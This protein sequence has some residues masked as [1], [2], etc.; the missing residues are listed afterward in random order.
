MP[1]RAIVGHRRAVE[2]LARAVA[3][4]SVPQSLIFAG[5]DGVGK[6]RT[7]VALAQALN[8]LRPVE[9]AS[10]AGRSAV[11]LRPST[12]SGRP[13]LAEGRDACGACSA[14][15]RI[16]RGMH[17]DVLFVRPDEESGATKIAQVR[18]AV[19]QAAYRPFE[20]R[21]RIIAFDDAESLLVAAQ[22]ALLKTLE[23]PPPSSVFV[24][25][26]SR[27][28]RLLPT[29]RS[30]CP[31]VR[32]GP[33]GADEVADVLMRD[34]GYA[35]PEAVASASQAR[36]SVGFALAAASGALVRARE[37]ARQLLRE[38]AR[39]DARQRIEAARQLG[40]PTGTVGEREQLAAQLQAFGSLLRDL[41]LLSTR[42]D[43]RALANR[44]LKP[45][46]ET[47]LGSYGPER[48]NRAFALVDRA[49]AALERNASPKIV[50]GWLAVRV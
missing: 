13:E 8:C 16:A 1:F 24:L 5:P 21:R 6:R 39:A 40:K 32:F 44:D 23:E 11:P 20:G 15:Q 49:L 46:L 12:S 14:C 26:T 31:R 2:L 29:V 36:G 50:A 18:E 19:E 10:G 27:P 37:A 4:D 28:D 3:R 38:V 45:E 17:P 47:V 43:D 7:A 25:I 30:R 9:M 35:Q 33:L 42:G 34:H 22:N 41:V 48:S